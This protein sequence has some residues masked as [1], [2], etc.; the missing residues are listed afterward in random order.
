M[1]KGKKV[2]KIPKGNGSF[3]KSHSVHLCHCSLYS[4]CHANLPFT[5]RS[6]F[7]SLSGGPDKGRR[8]PVLLFSA[9][10]HS[11][12][13]ACCAQ[14]KAKQPN[15]HIKRKG[16]AWALTDTSSFPGTSGV[17]GGQITESAQ[18][19]SYRWES[20]WSQLAMW[21]WNTWE[22]SVLKLDMQS[23]AYKGTYKAR[24]GVFLF[25]E[26]SHHSA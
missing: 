17:K 20:S 6:V 14:Y 7:F 19:H 21:T 3:Y 10:M 16:G 5:S 4:P 26:N 12:S 23:L 24:Q 22:L 25:R 18:A 9:G 13:I 15:V 2:L 1:T 8:I 11:L